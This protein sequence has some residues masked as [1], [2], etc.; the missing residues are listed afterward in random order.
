MPLQIKIQFPGNRGNG[1]LELD[2]LSNYSAKT[3]VINGKKVISFD[4]LNLKE[5]I[6]QR[7][8][9]FYVNGIPVYN[10]DFE[11]QSFQFEVFKLHYLLISADQGFSHASGPDE[12]T[13]DSVLIIDL[14][15]AKR[16]FMSLPRSRLTRSKEFLFLAY[17]YPADT[18]IHKNANRFFAIDSL[19]VTNK[20]IVLFAQSNERQVFD[21]YLR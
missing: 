11:K 4:S 13:R 10:G 17:K 5:E 19:D 3:E 14:N 8:F 18:A 20:K 6:I 21:L 2:F 1:R 7:K 15:S 16:Y 9:A 12:F